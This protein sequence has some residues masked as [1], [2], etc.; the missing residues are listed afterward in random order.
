MIFTALDFETT[1]YEN[2]GG[3]EPWQLGVAVVEDLRIVDTR[4]WFFGTELTPDS[5]TMMSQWDEFIPYLAGRRLVAHNIATERTILTRVAPLT[6]WGPWVDTLKLARARY[7]RLPSYTLGDLCR[8]FGCVPEIDGR[9]WHDGLY[10]AVA[11]ANLA[12]FLAV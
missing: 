4:E 10:D 7:P 11:C 2:G 12:C 3:N 6:K 5:P 8:M 1:G 9:T